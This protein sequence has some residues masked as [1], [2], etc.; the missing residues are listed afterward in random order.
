MCLHDKKNDG[1]VTLDSARWGE[2]RGVFENKKRRGIS[3]GDMIDITRGNYKGFDVIE[4]YIDIVSDLK[5]RG[6]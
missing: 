2:F 3:H 5:N 4:T 1:L 6:F